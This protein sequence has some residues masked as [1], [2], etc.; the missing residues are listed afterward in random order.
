MARTIKST[1]HEIKRGPRKGQF[2]WK[3]GPM[4][5][6]DPRNARAKFVGAYA[7]EHKLTIGAASREVKEKGL[8]GWKR[9]PEASPDTAGVRDA[10]SL[11]PVETVVAGSGAVGLGPVAGL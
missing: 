11:P 5:S 4:L 1:K 7:K 6:D 10:A 8:T 3:R 2:I 9:H